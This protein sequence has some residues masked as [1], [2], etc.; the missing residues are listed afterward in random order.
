MIAAGERGR[1]AGFTGRRTRPARAGA[2]A[3][4]IGT[5]IGG[6]GSL[7]R[8]HDVI[9]ARRGR[10]G[11]PHC[12]IPKDMPNGSARVRGPGNR[13]PR[14]RSH[15]GERL[16]VGAEAVAYGLDSIELD[17]ADVVLVGGTEALR[18]SAHPFQASPQMQAMST[19]NDEPER[20]SRP[21]DKGRDGFV[22]GEGAGALVL[23][24]R[25]IS[26][27]SGPGAL[28]HARRSGHH[29]RCLRHGGTRPERGRTAPR[30]SHSA[31]ATRP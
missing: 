20:A 25:S 6:A 29:L 21:F 5:G 15:T 24:R 17:R 22:L 14:R 26:C 2:V 30:R 3:V 23:E 1:H 16:R 27:R 31:R 9:L 7:I 18:S 10:A 28:C 11:S 12:S 8:E 4:V 13:R 19:R